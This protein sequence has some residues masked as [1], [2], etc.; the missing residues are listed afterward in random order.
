MEP[1]A[2]YPVRYRIPSGLRPKVHGKRV[3]V[4]ND[5]I[6]AG[7]AV[8]GTVTD[9]AGCGARPAVIATLLVLGSW[10]FEYSKAESLALEN[11]ASL[12][13]TLWAPADCP[14]CRND[15]PLVANVS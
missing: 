12:P 13:N 8:S 14:L 3:A 5:V 10:A 2:L 6:N 9:L 15:I 11:L 7:S 4:V 1:Q